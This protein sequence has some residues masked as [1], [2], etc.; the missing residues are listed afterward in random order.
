LPGGYWLIGKRYVQGCLQRIG[1]IYVHIAP[2]FIMI[3]VIWLFT[4]TMQKMGEGYNIPPPPFSSF[5][6]HFCSLKAWL[7]FA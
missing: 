5:Q 3:F 2:R 1:S 7:L 6:I 4:K